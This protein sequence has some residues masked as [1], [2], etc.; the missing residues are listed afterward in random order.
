MSLSSNAV[1]FSS[2][3]KVKVIQY[4]WMSCKGHDY[5]VKVTVQQHVPVKGHDYMKAKDTLSVNIS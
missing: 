2:Y 5:K 3:H 4:Q 1:S